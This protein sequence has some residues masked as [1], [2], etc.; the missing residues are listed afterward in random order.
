[1]ETFTFKIVDPNFNLDDGVICRTVVAIHTS[2]ESFYYSVKATKELEELKDKFFSISVEDFFFDDTYV[3]A[4]YYL[5]DLKDIFD[6]D[7]FDWFNFFQ[8]L[9]SNVKGD[10]SNETCKD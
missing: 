2:P 5:C 7:F 1:M 9:K 8:T 4:C 6:K 10:I 3:K